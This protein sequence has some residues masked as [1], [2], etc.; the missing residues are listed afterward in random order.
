MVCRM[1]RKAPCVK[2][3]PT[4]ALYQEELD[5]IVLVDE[6]LCSGCGACEKV[7]PFEAIWINDALG[8][9]LKCDLCGGAPICVE[10]CPTQALAYE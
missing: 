6:S 1:C 8:I 7:C 2:A 10:H 9:A 5:G 4:E 3:C